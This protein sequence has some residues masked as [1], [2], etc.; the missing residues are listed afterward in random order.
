MKEGTEFQGEYEIRKGYQG[1]GGRWICPLSY[2]GDSL[3]NARVCQNVSNG[4]P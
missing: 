3:A 2:C 1:S 4:L